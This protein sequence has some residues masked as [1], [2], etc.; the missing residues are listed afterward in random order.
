MLADELEPGASGELFGVLVTTGP[1]SAQE[2]GLG[3]L[4][5]TDGRLLWVEYIASAPSIRKDC[6]APDR[7]KPRVLGVGRQLMCAAIVRSRDLGLEGRIGLHAE[8]PSAA[9][10]NGWGMRSVGYASHRT[11]GAFPVFFGDAT[12]AAGFVDRAG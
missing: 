9:V 11:G 2:A 3:E 10:Y 8:G 6:P 7:R 12:W 1:I 5:A 4:L